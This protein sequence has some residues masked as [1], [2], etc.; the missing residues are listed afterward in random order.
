MTAFNDDLLRL[1][2]AFSPA[3]EH[4]FRLP[5]FS[6]AKHRLITEIHDWAG[7]LLEHN[8]TGN[9]LI[10]AGDHDHR[11]LIHFQLK[12]SNGNRIFLNHCNNF[13]GNIGIT[14]TNNTVVLCGNSPW[15]SR[16]NRNLN[17]NR[18]FVFIG[19]GSTFVGTDI[20]PTGDDISVICGDDCMFSHGTM[21]RTYDQHSIFDVDT[22]D[23]V[24]K[25]DSVLIGPHVW[26][27]Q[28]TLILKGSRIGAGSI[29]GA[30]STLS[31]VIAPMSVC[32][33][34]PAKIVRSRVCWTRE[35]RPS[36]SG[37][38]EIIATYRGDGFMDSNYV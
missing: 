24:N 35:L 15:P 20:F 17:G 1:V 23:W 12:G 34:S 38:D 26:V 31:S 18:N 27:G 21:I 10:E 28:E 36:E 2:G 22:K 14:G 29:V 9:E 8:A 33:G 11:L 13:N 30:R 3:G 25:P 4:H 5:D 16:L 37:M 7:S 19:S 6:A 32:V